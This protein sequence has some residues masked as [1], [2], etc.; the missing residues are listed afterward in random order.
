MTAPMVLPAIL[1]NCGALGSVD[2]SF[3]QASS[4]VERYDEPDQ[5]RDHAAPEGPLAKP[6]GS[7]LSEPGFPF[8]TGC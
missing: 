6:T 5:V 3:S 7:S 1:S 8:R 2:R 4:V